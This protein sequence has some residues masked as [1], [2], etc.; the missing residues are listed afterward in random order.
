M[1]IGFTHSKLQLADIKK[2]SNEHGA[3]YSFYKLKFTN[4]DKVTSV[5]ATILEYRLCS[6]FMKTSVDM[7]SRD[8]ILNCEFDVNITDGFFYRLDNGVLIKKAGNPKSSYIN[9]IDI[10]STISVIEGPYFSKYQVV[11]GV[12]AM[13]I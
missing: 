12:N 9:F 8:E 4:L 2:I 13:A 1:K 10:H 11:D 6:H 3:P 7:I 5:A